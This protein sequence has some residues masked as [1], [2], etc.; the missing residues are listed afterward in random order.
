VRDGYYVDATADRNPLEYLRADDQGAKV[1]HVSPRGGELQRIPYAPP[2]ENALKRTYDVWLEDDGSARIEFV[3]ESVGRYAVRLRYMLG[4][5]QGDIEKNLADELGAGFGDIQID[6]IET[7]DLE[8]IDTPVRVAAT[9]RARDLWVPQ[10]TERSLRL[11]FDE[12]RLEG[13]AVETPDERS[14]ELVLDR[15]FSYETVVRWHLPKGMQVTGRPA[16][17]TNSGSVVEYELAL[18]ELDDGIAVKR[19]FAIAERRVELASYADLR[20]AVQRARIAEERTI[21]IGAKG[22]K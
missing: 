13:L 16:D 12:L 1:L 20:E 17:V 22:G 18:E 10:G 5:E 9:F 8:A 15:P 3:D 2:A 19:R 14:H 4:G 21:S 7:S 11:A 6:S